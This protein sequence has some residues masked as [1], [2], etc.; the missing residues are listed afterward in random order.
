MKELEMELTDYLNKIEN[1]EGDTLQNP[2]A[3]YAYMMHLTQVM[4][5][6]NYIMADYKRKVRLQKVSSYLVLFGSSAAQQ[7]NFAPTLAK[8]YVEAKGHEAAFIYDLAERLSRCAVHTIDAL[9]TI[10]SS[11]KNERS[12]VLY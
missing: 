3:L 11:L 9:R 6:A 4:A 7:K 12:T 2:H 5:R 1:F 8:D 10:I